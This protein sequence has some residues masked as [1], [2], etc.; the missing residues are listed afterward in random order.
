MKSMTERKNSKG[1]TL[2]ELMVVVA[3][4]AIIASIAIPAY[5]QYVIR[6]KRS[7]AKAA[8]LDVAN[9]MEKA[10]Y[11]WNTYDNGGTLTAASVI[12][13]IPG[14][15][16]TSNDGYYALSFGALTATSYTITATPTGSFTDSDCGAL[17]Y[18]QAGNKTAAA[19]DNEACWR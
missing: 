1:V 9:R 13:L 17:S 3:I 12:T 5:D 7:D 6:A 15:S 19:G 10:L 11:D 4:V 18:D 2:I 8:L 16:A 14:V